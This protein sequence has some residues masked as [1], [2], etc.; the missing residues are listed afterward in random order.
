MYELLLPIVLYDCNYLSI[1]PNP[2]MIKP[3][4]LHFHRVVWVVFVALAVGGLTW[5]NVENWKKYHSHPKSINVEVEHND[6]LPFPAVTIC[7]QHALKYV[8]TAVAICNQHVLKYITPQSPSVSN[9]H[10]ST[11]TP[12][13]PHMI[14]MHSST[15][16]QLSLYVINTHSSAHTLLSPYVTNMHSSM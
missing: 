16:I 7:N 2:L 5:I 13:P 9:M 8:H 6:S 4:P 14:N 3:T 10:S 11:Y 15:Y 1:P 12:L